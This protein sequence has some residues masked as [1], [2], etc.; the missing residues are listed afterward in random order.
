MPETDFEKLA[1]QLEE[2][3]SKLKG[4]KDPDERKALLRAMRLLL[5]EADRISPGLQS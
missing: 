1:Q 3:L 2:T 4:T 5:V